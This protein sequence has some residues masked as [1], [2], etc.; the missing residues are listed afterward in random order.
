MAGF[1]TVGI[2]PPS[3]TRLLMLLGGSNGPANH[4]FIPSNSVAN[5][6]PPGKSLISVSLVGVSSSAETL[7]PSVTKQ[8]RELFGPPVDSWRFLRSYSI[9]QA[10]PAQPANFYHQPRLATLQDGTVF[11]G[12]YLETSSIQGALVSG[13]KAATALLNAT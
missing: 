10:L 2:G 13:R 9:P 6:A 12:D 4:I 8:L 11:C 3:G 1:G 7:L 5:F